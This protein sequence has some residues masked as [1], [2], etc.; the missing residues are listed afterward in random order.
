[1]IELVLILHADCVPMVSVLFC[2]DRKAM[3]SF[4]SLGEVPIRVAARKVES[5]VTQAQT[6]P[7]WL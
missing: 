2:T 5:S 7:A 6:C 3:N 4:C 1:M